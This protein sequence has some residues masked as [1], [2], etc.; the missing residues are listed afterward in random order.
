MPSASRLISA[1]FFHRELVLDLGDDQ[2]L[3]G[4]PL[5][6]GAQLPHICGLTHEGHGDEI[7]ARGETDLHVG[8][9]FR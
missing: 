6:D 7:H 3:V 5:D 4:G 9:V 2:R 1:K 8:E